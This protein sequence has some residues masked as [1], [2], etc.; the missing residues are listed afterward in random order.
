MLEA[1]KLTRREVS[2]FEKIAAIPEPKFQA[3]LAAP[4]P[5]TT[6]PPTTPK[7]AAMKVAEQKAR[8]WDLWLDCLTQQAIAGEIGVPQQ[9]VSDWLTEIGKR[10]DFGKPRGSTAAAP[11]PPTT[12]PV[13]PGPPGSRRGLGDPGAPSRETGRGFVILD[14]RLGR[15]L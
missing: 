1:T 7:P 2:R 4:I 11:I 12:R 3:A 5:P 13:D 14:F 15:F 8:A 10:S 6:R 9:T